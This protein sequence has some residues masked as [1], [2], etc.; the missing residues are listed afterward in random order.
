MRPNTP[1]CERLETAIT[2]IARHANYP[3]K[4]D[5]VADC[6]REIDARWERGR[7]TVPQRFRLYAILQ[8]GASSRQSGP[9]MAEIG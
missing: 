3:G 5:V 9:A 7:L 6:A 2:V 4:A 8:E 1:S